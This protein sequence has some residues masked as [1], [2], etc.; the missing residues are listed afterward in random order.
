M[1]P[2]F[3]SCVPPVMCPLLRFRYPN[4]AV[5]VFVVHDNFR[6]TATPLLVFITVV[7]DSYGCGDIQQLSPL[8][9]VLRVHMS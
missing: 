7:M 4:G 2:V 9:Y 1:Y 5:V 3:W 8:G 6:Y